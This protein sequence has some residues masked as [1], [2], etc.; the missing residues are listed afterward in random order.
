MLGKTL[1]EDETNE[2]P[3]LYAAGQSFRMIAQ[4]FGIGVGKAAKIVNLAGVASR[5]QS[6]AAVIGYQRR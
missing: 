4:R 2:I 5:S 1:T 6:D 3:A